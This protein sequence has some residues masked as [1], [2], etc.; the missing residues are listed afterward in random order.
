MK[1]IYHRL[2]PGKYFM[3]NQ[4][5]LNKYFSTDWRG[6]ISERA[7]S[8]PGLVGKVG[9]D[10]WVLDVGCGF[11]FFKGQIKNFVGIDPAND[12][13]CVKVSIEQFQSPIIFDVAFCL[14]SVN[15]GSEDDIRNDIACVVSHLRQ[16][17]RI[18]WRCN[19][20]LHDHAKSSF[21]EI[22]VFPWTIELQHQ[23]AAEFGFTIKE[24]AWEPG[25][26]IYAEWV[27]Q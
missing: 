16:K 12:A 2:T 27:R 6:R 14:G 21:E 22:A 7:M 24:I 15:F 17:A 9:P 20:G 11:N 8:G 3:K 10:E 25:N 5:Q 23:F 26:R 13:A 4:I 19:P 1:S 18:Y